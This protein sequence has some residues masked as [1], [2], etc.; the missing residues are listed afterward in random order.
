MS[1]LP[2]SFWLL[3]VRWVDERFSSL[4]TLCYC[5]DGVLAEQEKAAKAEEYKAE[6]E[7]IKAEQEEAEAEEAGGEEEGR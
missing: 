6:A 5:R 3:V 4:L 1:R 7:T 2:W